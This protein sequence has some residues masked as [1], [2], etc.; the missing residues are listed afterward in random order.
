MLVLRWGSKRLCST[1]GEKRKESLRAG[2]DER[3]KTRRRVMAEVRCAA[4]PWS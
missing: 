1:G 4:Y 3:K 2:G